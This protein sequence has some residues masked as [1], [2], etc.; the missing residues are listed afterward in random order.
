MRAV[1]SNPRTWA[2][3][4]WCRA[5]SPLPDPSA[6]SRGAT[7]RAVE[8]TDPNSRTA[9]RQLLEKARKGRIDVYFVGDS[10][11]R[12]WGATDYPEFLTNWEKNFHGWNAADFGWGGDTVQ[13]GEAHEYS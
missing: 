1:V 9:H 5:S 7:D 8:R 6:G 12:R 11:T 2:R 13:S 10:I 3:S 4:Q